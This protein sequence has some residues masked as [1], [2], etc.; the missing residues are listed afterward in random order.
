MMLMAA[1]SFYDVDGGTAGGSV[2]HP[3]ARTE[4]RP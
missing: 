1:K 2:R 4:S 3:Y